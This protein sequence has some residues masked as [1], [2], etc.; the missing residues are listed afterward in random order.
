MVKVSF[1]KFIIVISSIFRY[2]KEV[3]ISPTI[4]LH[5]RWKKH[6]TAILPTAK[7]GHWHSCSHPNGV[8][9]RF[10]GPNFSLIAMTIAHSRHRLR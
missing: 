1:F 8:F 4:K 3:E 9:N 5:Q 6:Q 2:K 10:K 7:D